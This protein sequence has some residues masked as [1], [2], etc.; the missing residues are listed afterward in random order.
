M[1]ENLP[2]E[3]LLQI[4]LYLTFDSIKR[5]REVCSSWETQIE[6]TGLLS[7]AVLVVSPENKDLVSESKLFSI[8]QTIKVTKFRRE[9]SDKVNGILKQFRDKKKNNQCSWKYLSLDA[10]IN[11]NSNMLF[12]FFSNLT[13]I[14]LRGPTIKDTVLVVL[15]NEFFNKSDFT[16]DTLILECRVIN[17]TISKAF[18]GSS[19]TSRVDIK[20]PCLTSIFMVNVKIEMEHSDSDHYFGIMKISD[21]LQKQR[22]RHM[23]FVLDKGKRKDTGTSGIK[24]EL[25]GQNSKTLFFNLL[26]HEN[27]NVKA[28]QTPILNSNWRTGSRRS[29]EEESKISHLNVQFANRLDNI[30]NYKRLCPCVCL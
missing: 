17:T 22:L 19:F 29:Q 12:P 4:A 3:I 2:T 11:V 23:S 27:I 28:I 8:V 20:H 25:N 7:L 6:N 15:L 14:D 30:L 5:C 16:L 26:A 10:C 24:I 18:Q 21:R 9:Q 1:I 13:R